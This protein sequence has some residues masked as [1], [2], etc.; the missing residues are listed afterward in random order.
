[1]SKNRPEPQ[2]FWR[3]KIELFFQLLSCVVKIKVHESTKNHKK[4]GG[5]GTLKGL[6]KGI[7]NLIHNCMHM[8]KSH[9]PHLSQKKK[10]KN[11]FQPFGPF[12]IFDDLLI[13]V[14]S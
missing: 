11:D 5:I 13:M 9:S 10:T 7:L 6:N 3:L 4:W 12:P 14:D 8:V 2:V 1:M